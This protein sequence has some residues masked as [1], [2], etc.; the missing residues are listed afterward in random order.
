MNDDGQHE[1]P[2][3]PKELFSEYEERPFRCCT[4]CGETLPDF[5]E[6]YRISKV[7]KRGEVIFEYALCFYCLERMMEESSEES[8]KRL[9]DFQNERMREEI[10]GLDQCVLCERTRESLFPPEFALVAG[11]V[12]NGLLDSHLICIHCMEDMSALVSEK[13]RSGWNRFVEENFPGIPSDFL[14][15]PSEGTPAP[16]L[17]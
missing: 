2:P 9:M 11:C 14:P 13:T 12:G 7:V 1:L 17:I 10:T 4:R 15:T 3:I 5:E 8:Q 6:G 16:V